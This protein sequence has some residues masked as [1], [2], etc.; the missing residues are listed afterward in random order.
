MD[1]NIRIEIE[2]HWIIC[3]HDING[4]CLECEEEHQPNFPRAIW[5]CS[6]TFHKH[7]LDA[8]LKKQNTCPIDE[9]EWA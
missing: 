9:K 1:T 8:W 3:H 2:S 4:F 7:C 5:K 6:H